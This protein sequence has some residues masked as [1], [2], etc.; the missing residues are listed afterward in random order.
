[1]SIA[2]QPVSKQ[3]IVIT[4]ASSGIG[5]ATALAAARR[6]ANVVMAARNEEALRKI[7]ADISQ[8]GGKAAVCSADVGSRDDVERIARTAIDSFGGFDTWVNDAGVDIWGRL[9]DVSDEDSRRLFDTNFWGVVHGST[10]AARHLR[11]RGGAII[12]VGSVASDPRISAAGHVLRQQT[13][14]QSLHGRA[15]HGAR[16]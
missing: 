8:E 6:G 12:N 5:L 15:A 3:T 13:C 7:A 9:E 1:M 11:A 14:R 4:G 16:T 2:L 10:V